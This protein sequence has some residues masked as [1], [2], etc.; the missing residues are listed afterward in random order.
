V[1]S[2]QFAQGA[3]RQLREKDLRRA[4][5]VSVP[6]VTGTR[7]V[8]N[9]QEVISIAGGLELNTPIWANEMHEYPYLQW[10]AEVHRAKLKSGVSA[11][12]GE[13]RDFAGTRRGGRVRA[14]VTVERR[15]GIAD[16]S[17]R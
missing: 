9:G 2:S 7:R 11:R 3:A 16:D 14:R 1:Q 13:N 4:E 10:Q 5:R 8:P 12:G 15:A 6:R 17:S